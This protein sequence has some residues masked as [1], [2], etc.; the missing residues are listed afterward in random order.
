MLISLKS[1]YTVNTKTP[2]CLI[3]AVYNEEHFFTVD[4]FILLLLNKYTVHKIST[5]GDWL[6]VKGLRR[7]GNIPAM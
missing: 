2:V 4:L 3:F 1:S 6:L 5:S 7:I